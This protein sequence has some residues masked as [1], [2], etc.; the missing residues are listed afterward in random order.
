VERF[1]A[2]LRRTGAWSHRRAEQARAALWAEI[3]ATLVENF[4]TAPTVARH[5]STIEH[6]VM[7]GRRTPRAAARTLLTAFLG[8]G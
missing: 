1:H 2:V 8:E 7:A 4:R 6:E 5:L 3:G